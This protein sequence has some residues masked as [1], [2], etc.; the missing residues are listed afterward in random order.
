MPGDTF[1]VAQD[2][3]FAGGGSLPAWPLAT[4]VIRWPPHPPLSCDEIARR[5]RLHD[6]S[7]LPRIRED[8]IVFDLRTIDEREFEELTAAVG[9]SCRK[10]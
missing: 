7:V 9:D 10:K 3:S 8:A 6:P 2:E 5:L 4:A 1:T